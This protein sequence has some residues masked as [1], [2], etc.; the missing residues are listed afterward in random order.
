MPGPRTVVNQFVHE[1]ARTDIL[2]HVARYAEQGLP[3]IARRFMASVLAAIGAIT[4]APHGGPPKPLANQALTGLRSWPVK[5]FDGFWI[6]YL[7][8]PSQLTIARVLHG[9]RDIGTVLDD[10]PPRP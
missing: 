4:A 7:H 5:G 2:R 10:E 8:N 6:Y 3:N 1:T 9:K